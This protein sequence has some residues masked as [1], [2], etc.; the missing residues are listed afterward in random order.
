[1]REVQHS[2]FGPDMTFEN[3]DK[4]VRMYTDQG[5]S[6]LAISKETGI[7]YARLRKLLTSRGLIIR[8]PGGRVPPGAE[9]PSAKLQPERRR[10]LEALLLQ[11]H[12]HTWLAKHFDIS[13][14]RVRQIAREIGSPTGKELHDKARADRQLQ[15]EA[16]RA[17]RLEERRV[18]REEEYDVWRKLWA[19]GKTITEIAHALHLQPGSVSVR[20]V[21]LRKKYPEWFPRRRLSRTDPK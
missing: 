4:L 19:C 7:S 20:I 16:A 2:P 11:G 8:G 9:H 5:Y 12:R 13:R 6:M 1:M 21:L 14:E 3:L 10:E 17:K 18:R 15:A